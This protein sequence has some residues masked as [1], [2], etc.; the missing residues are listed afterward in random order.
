MQFLRQR[1][2]EKDL[3]RLQLFVCD[4]HSCK[5]THAIFFSHTRCKLPEFYLTR[6]CIFREKKSLN[7]KHKVNPFPSL[8]PCFFKEKKRKHR[9]RENIIRIVQLRN[10]IFEYTRPTLFSGRQCF[11]CIFTSLDTKF[12]IY[13]CRLHA[14]DAYCTSSKSCISHTTT[15]T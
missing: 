10:G 6:L 3:L 1:K 9:K 11:W 5:C 12:S 8:N 4:T 2:R 13:C 15:R 14:C 7:A